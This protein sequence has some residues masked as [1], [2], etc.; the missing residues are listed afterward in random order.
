[1][2]AQSY[3]PSLLKKQQFQVVHVYICNSYVC[4]FYVVKALQLYFFNC[5]VH[6]K[7]RWILP[8]N[9]SKIQHCMI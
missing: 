8:R 3:P 7:I 2:S 6:I 1:M 5:E 4:L 9:A